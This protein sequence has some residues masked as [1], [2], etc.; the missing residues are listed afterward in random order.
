MAAFSS[1]FMVQKKKNL[2][3]ETMFSF[4]VNAWVLKFDCTCHISTVILERSIGR[5]LSF[6]PSPMSIVASKFTFFYII[7]YLFLSLFIL[8]ARQTTAEALCLGQAITSTSFRRCRDIAKSTTI[9][10]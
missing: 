5:F 2:S 3:T 8:L 4:F 9:N 10:Y 7:F 6:M 1:N